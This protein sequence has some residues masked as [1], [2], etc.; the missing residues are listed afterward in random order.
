M[1]NPRKSC[2]G[3][4]TDARKGRSR[5]I[6][7]HLYCVLWQRAA[8]PHWMSSLSAKAWVCLRGRVCKVVGVS[9]TKACFQPRSSCPQD[10]SNPEGITIETEHCHCSFLASSGPV[11]TEHGVSQPA[12]G[13]PRQV[14]LEKPGLGILRYCL[15]GA[16]PSSVG[17]HC[18]K[19]AFL[20][21]VI[22]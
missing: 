10:K 15:P 4:E 13:P 18:A 9:P 11:R 5:F 14:R 3:A 16:C 22:A 1:M 8:S 6:P 17:T 21:R 12:L 7:L 19:P 20:E 2:D